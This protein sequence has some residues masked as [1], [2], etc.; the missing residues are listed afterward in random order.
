MTSKMLS[1]RWFD[2]IP[3]SSPR[4]IPTTATRAAAATAAYVGKDGAGWSAGA[5]SWGLVRGRMRPRD[6]RV[7]SNFVVQALN[8]EPITVY[9]D[10]SQTRSFCYVDDE[11]EGIYALFMRGDPMPTNIGNPEEYTVGQLAMLVKELT[12]ATSP[13]EYRP[14]PEDDPKV[15]KPDIARAR[16]MLGWEPK[17]PVR[18]GLRRTIDYFKT[19]V[20]T[21]RM[22]QA[23]TATAVGSRN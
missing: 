1:H 16:A 13:I 12:R 15:R 21:A 18:E 2:A 23:S 8:G 19:L 5:A 14:L 20:G 3:T 9:G 4:T 17:V 22:T 10:G 6:G 7:V 11:I